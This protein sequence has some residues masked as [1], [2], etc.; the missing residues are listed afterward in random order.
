MKI[1]LSFLV[2]LCIA[3]GSP[4]VFWEGYQWNMPYQWNFPI[5]YSPPLAWPPGQVFPAYNCLPA[6]CNCPPPKHDCPPPKY[7][8]SSA[9]QQF[10]QLLTLQMNQENNSMNCTIGSI[11]YDPKTGHTIVSISPEQQMVI[12]PVN[13]STNPV[14]PQANNTQPSY[15]GG[16]GLIDPRMSIN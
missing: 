3:K 16:E 13:N 14:T 2:L 8:H 12:K 5:K 6:Q 10:E 1:I 11:C 9:C 15:H 4:V 7:I